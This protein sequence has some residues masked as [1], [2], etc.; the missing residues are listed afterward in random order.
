MTTPPAPILRLTGIGL[1]ERPT[2]GTLEIASQPTQSLD[3]T[4]PA[5]KAV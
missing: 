3:D 5:G 4:E 1:L 2:S